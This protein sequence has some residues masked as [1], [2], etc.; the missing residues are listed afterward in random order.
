MSSKNIMTAFL[1][2]RGCQK[3]QVSPEGLP[4]THEKHVHITSHTQ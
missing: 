1:I 2:P 3:A 4:G